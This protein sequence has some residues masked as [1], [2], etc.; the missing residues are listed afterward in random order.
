MEVESWG[1]VSPHDINPGDI[2]VISIGQPE[3]WEVT[4]VDRWPG[5]TTIHAGGWTHDFLKKSG[6]MV[7]RETKLN[8]NRIVATVAKMLVEAG[9]ERVAGALMQMFGAGGAK[10]YE[11]EE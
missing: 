11:V 4:K 10:P 7:F 9:E 6:P 1:R 3:P 5:W 8:R 2:V